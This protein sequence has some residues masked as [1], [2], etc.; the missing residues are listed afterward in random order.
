MRHPMFF[1]YFLIFISIYV[2]LNGYIFVHGYR[3]VG[4]FGIQPMMY[5]IIF[6]IFASSYIVGELIQRN[7]S[8]IISDILITF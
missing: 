2:L 4:Q 6:L 8:S 5:S 3:M 1:L 7:H